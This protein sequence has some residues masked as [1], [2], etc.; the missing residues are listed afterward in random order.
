MRFVD[1]QGEPLAGQLTDFLSDHR[2]FLQ[3][4]DD[5]CL[6][7]F[8]RF[9]ELARGRID[10]FHN[11]Q[12]LLEL[13]HCGLEGAVEHAPVRDHHNRIENASVFGVVQRGQLVGEPGDGKRL[14]ASGRVL[15]EIALP[16]A[17]P[18]SIGN[19]LTHTIEL[20]VAREDQRLSAGLAAVLVFLLDFVDELPHQVQHA[21]A[22]PGLLPEVRRGIAG[23]RGR[24][25][26]V[27]RTAVVALV[28]GK[29]A[30]LDTG[31]AGGDVDQ[32]RIDRE[33]RQAAA[34][35]QQR[36]PAGV[37]VRLVLA[38]CVLDGLTAE[39]VLEFGGEN[40]DAVQKQDQIQTLL[41]LRAVTYLADDREKVGHIQLARLL[42][43]PAGRPE[44]CQA[45]RAAHILDAVPKH[46]EN[47]AAVDF[48]R[49]AP[50]K[51]ISD[52]SAVVM[53]Q[54]LP[55][56]RLRRNDEIQNVSG[57]K[58]KCA[59]VVLGFSLEV[60]AGFHSLAADRQPAFTHTRRKT[61]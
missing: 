23:L 26:R 56:L 24:N 11:P 34:I 49:Q 14:A 35:G 6:P 36:L 31:K 29:E 42:V 59:V 32:F 21:V 2:E 16:R 4:G 5:N 33:M 44:V 8:K 51:A 1:N 38:D 20:L 47:A 46:V 41:I 17:C 55:F 10:V 13:A 12:G 48:R 40:W 15:D 25:W 27:P 22:R 39:Q 45:E 30:C 58:A 7:G 18:S 57:Q 3:R 60:T 37:A 52:L 9:F 53:G 54:L 50:E 28:K 43:K 61:S 19:E